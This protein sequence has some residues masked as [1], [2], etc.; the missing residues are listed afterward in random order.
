MVQPVIVAVLADCHIHPGGGPDW[1]PQILEAL[2]GVDLIVTLG[3]MGEAA[4]LDRLAQIAPVLGV[5]GQD[6]SDD[7]RTAQQVRVLQLGTTRLGCV[8]DPV[9][10]GLA[11]SVDP[12]TPD[13]NFRPKCRELFGGEIT[14]LLYA[15][16]HTPQ[17][18]WFPGCMALNPGSATLPTGMEDGVPGAFVRLSVGENRFDFEFVEIR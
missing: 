8:F 5:R 9:A 15:S 13:F 2:A 18:S 17:S 11:S 3:D 4:G 1:T 16:T 6:D 14:A 12:F 7:P 10:A